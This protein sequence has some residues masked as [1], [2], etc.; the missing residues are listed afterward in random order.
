[1]C[2]F[3]HVTRLSGINNR[4][5]IPIAHLTRLRPQRQLLRSQMQRVYELEFAFHSLFYDVTRFAYALSSRNLNIERTRFMIIAVRYHC[6]T[7]AA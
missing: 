1:M 5:T 4:S 7:L 6:G 3:T 2:I